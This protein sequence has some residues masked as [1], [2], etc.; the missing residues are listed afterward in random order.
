MKLVTWGNWHEVDNKEIGKGLF[1]GGFFVCFGIFKLKYRRNEKLPPS[2]SSSSA[3]SQAEKLV[4]LDQLILKAN[5]DCPFHDIPFVCASCS[6]TT[7]KAL[8]DIFFSCK[9]VN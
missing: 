4:L 1:G 8:W 2:Q 7:H 5:K 3:F 9:M 6:Y